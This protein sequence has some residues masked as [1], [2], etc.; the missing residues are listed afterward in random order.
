MTTSTP[1]TPDAPAGLSRGRHWAVRGLLA[2]ATVLAVVSIFAVWANRQVLDADN[3]ADTSSALLDN[4]EIRAQVSGFLVDSVYDN[5]DVGAEVGSTLP[6]RFKPLAAPVAN[7]LRNLAQ[8]TTDRALARP[9]L[10][11]AWKE[12]NKLTAQ[13]FINIA[14][15]N[16][17]AVTSSGNAVILDLRVLV[18]N[19]AARLGLPSSIEGKIPP[20]AG[21]IKIMS[22]SQVSSVQNGVAALRGLAVILPAL[23]IAM[24]ALAVYLARGRRRQTLMFAGLA[25]I[26]AGLVVLVVRRITGGYVVDSL[27]TT[28]AAEPSADAAWSIASQMLRDVAQASV[29]IGIPVVVAAWLAGPR[30]PAVA[31][32]RALAPA[33]RDRPGTSYGVLALALL[34]V[35]AWGPIPATRMVVPVLLMVVLAAA[36]LAALRRQTAAEFPESAAAPAGTTLADHAAR[37]IRAVRDAGGGPPGAAAPV[38]AGGVGASA[39]PTARLEQLER[40]ST[41]HDRGALSDEEFTAE[42][43]AVLANGSLSDSSS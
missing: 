38:A 19:L 5:V 30:R 31:I 12:A 1:P 3:W 13:Q 27:A 24:L 20:D 18:V 11:Q 36:G 4:P 10:Q 29:V 33:L 7:A 8:E 35:V 26:A 9:R 16:S 32:R 42:K 22:S 34:L 25:L 41:L 2:G 15:G 21:R 39:A 28:A 40:L 23:A 14:E 6:P 17:A 37:A 43:T